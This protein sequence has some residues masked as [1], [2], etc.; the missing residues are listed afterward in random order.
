MNVLDGSTVLGSCSLDPTG[1]SSAG[2]CLATYTPSAAGTAGLIAT[3]AGDSTHAASSSPASVLTVQLP[4]S[5]AAVSTPV[6]GAVEIAL[7]SSVTQLTEVDALLRNA[8]PGLSAEL[9]NG[10]I[11]LS[12]AMGTT[13]GSYTVTI[14]GQGCTSGGCAI[15]IIAT[16]PV[17]I[18]SIAAPAGSLEEFTDPSSD[19]IAQASDDELQDELLIMLGSTDSPGTRAQADAA[20]SAVGGVVSGGLSDAGI[21]QVRWNSPQDLTARASQL[22]S[23]PDVSSVSDS[24]ID[25]NS[26]QSSYPE[27]D[28]AF[29]QPDYTWRYDQI[30]AQG[31]WNVSTGSNVTVG[32][33][34]ASSVDPDQGDL[35]DVKELNAVAP[36]TF[37]GDQANA[38]HATHVAGLACAKAYNAGMVGTAWGCPIVSARIDAIGSDADVML[39]MQE[40][41]TVPGVRVV[42]MSLASPTYVENV[43]LGMPYEGCGDAT[44]QQ[45]IEAHISHS[46]MFFRRLLAGVGKNI[47]WTFAAGNNCLPEA[48]SPYGANSDLDN[49]ITVGAT[50]SDGSLASFSNYGTDVN[51]AAPGGIVPSSPA[52]DVDRSCENDPTSGGTCGLLSTVFTNCGGLCDSYG[53]MSGT[54]M[55]APLVAGVAA[56]LIGANS[57][58]SADQVGDCIKTTAGT[59][60]VGNTSPPD[61]QPGGTFRTAPVNY[62]GQALLI[63]NATAA[64]ACASNGGPG[65]GSGSSPPQVTGGAV[66]AGEYH[67]CAVASGGGVECWGDNSSGELGDAGTTGPACSNTCGPT[68]VA[69]DGIT[70]ATAVASGAGFSCALLQS[71]NVECWGGNDLG[72][73]GDGGTTGPQTCQGSGCS[74]TPVA[75]TGLSNV[76]DIAAGSGSACAVLATRQVECW[77]E[78]VGRQGPTLIAG[79][80]DAVQVSVGGDGI[81]SSNACA[82]LAT[83]GVVCWSDK[84]TTVTAVGGITNATQVASDYSSSCALLSTGQVDCWGPWNGD[85]ELGDGTTAASAAPVAVTGISDAKAIGAGGGFGLGGEACAVLSSGVIDCWGLNEYGELGSGVRPGP[86]MCDD[87]WGNPTLSCSLAPVQVSTITAAQSVTAQGGHA[88]AS[89]AGGSLYCWGDNFSGDL[90]NDATTQSDVPVLVSSGS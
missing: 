30:D 41:T 31:A 72:Q 85:G 83:G 20:A 51:V 80:S 73:L 87:V 24:T 22:E 17:T 21:Y 75:V 76:V 65:G 38:E 55:A 52:V 89:T 48:S 16:I 42:N 7:P 6:G 54:S 74:T 69:V 46:E 4:I 86:T 82:V 27:V 77:G 49:V 81:L 62:T 33:I 64:V 9:D 84:S 32:I 28:P 67:T 39:A 23:H 56:D 44:D 60:G 1:A 13:T 11:G 19:R 37:A 12:A 59:D 18:T 78:L 47:V 40:M 29:N 25:L 66:A 68:P 90:G 71:G 88:C 35:N 45:N 8:P 50:N 3:Y 43:A 34:D 10:E 70:D 2:S 36:A 26:D 63:V 15:P 5:P 79:V 14:T 58:L 53:E 57:S 61:G